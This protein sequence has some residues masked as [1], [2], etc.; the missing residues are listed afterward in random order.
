MTPIKK[1]AFVVNRDK[2]GSGELA[3]TLV[4]ISENEGADTA[5]TTDYPLPSGFLDDMDACCVIGG[6]GS[7]L[8][9][10]TEA[11]GG[12]VPV[13]GVNLGKLGFM[14]SFSAQ[15][16]QSKLPEL[17]RGDYKVSERTVLHCHISSGDSVLALNDVV[18]KNIGSRLIRLQV[19]CKD[20]PVND[21]FCDGLIFTSPTGSTA[22]NLSAGGPIIHPDA[23][24]IAMTPIC[25]HT[26]SNRSVIFDQ[27]TSLKVTLLEKDPA[28]RITLDGLTSFDSYEN[29]PLQISISN[30]P[31]LLIQHLN[32]S[33]FQLVRNKLHWS[34]E[35]EIGP[36]ILPSNP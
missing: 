22:Y 28:V 10:V 9:V 35:S 6:D 29:F 32:L 17:L 4:E 19:L 20:E 30:L 2:E 15:E 25:P 36:P 16:A 5:V 8:G 31:F 7:L 21:Y 24:V 12:Q 33:H 13:L 34:G 27:N 1:I 3:S 11:V 14:A 26:L 18:V 23:R